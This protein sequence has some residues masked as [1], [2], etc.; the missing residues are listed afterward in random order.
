MIEYKTF[1]SKELKRIKQI[2]ESERW[3][4]YLDDDKKLKKAFDNSLFLYGAFSDESLV[5]FVRVVGDGEHVVLVQ[6]LI[7]MN[8]YQGKGIGS[9]LFS[10]VLD[11]YK[12]VR[13]F[14]VVADSNDEKLNEFYKSFGL[15]SVGSE[16][17]IA[18]CRK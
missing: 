9:E 17:M 16:Y 3:L 11:N 1:D 2:Y 15:V 13:F 7:V 5:G 6:D 18:Y 12:E 8:D 10:F 14:E 4:A